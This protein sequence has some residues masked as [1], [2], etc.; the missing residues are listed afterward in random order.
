MLIGVLAG[1][2]PAAA[3]RAAPPFSL[4]ERAVAIAS[5]ALVFVDVGLRGYLRNRVSGQL[6]DE[7]PAVVHRWC[8]GFAVSG[9]G[10]V[11]APT[12]CLLSHPDS[13][14][15]AAAFIV[16]NAMIAGGRLAPAAKN[17][18]IEQV[19]RSAEFTGAEPQSPPA[20]A[21]VTGQ[22]FV[23]TTDTER[24]TAIQGR[25]VDSQPV[26]GGGVTLLKFDT[27]GLPV[28]SL[29][30]TAMSPDLQVVQVSFTTS[31][32]EAQPATYIVRSRTARVTGSHGSSSPQRYRLDGDLGANSD[33][34]MVIDTRGDVIGMITHDQALPGRPNDLL[35][36][37]D[38]ILS[39]LSN[40]GVG[41]ELAPTDEVYRAGLDAY[42]GGYYSDA[43][44]RFESVLAQ[45]PNNLPAQTY[46][47]HATE[48]LAIEG[49]PRSTFPA[50]T[51]IASVATIVVLLGVIAAL[52]LRAW[53]SRAR[54]RA[55]DDLS[56]L[57]E[58]GQYHAV[59][60]RHPPISGAP[61]SG[62]AGA[63][64]SAP[65]DA[66]TAHTVPAGHAAQAVPAVPAWPLAVPGTAP[67]GVPTWAPPG[68]ATSATPGAT[69]ATP[70]WTPPPTQADVAWAPRGP[71]DGTGVAAPG[72]APGQATPPAAAAYPSTTPVAA[73]PAVTF[74]R[75]QSQDGNTVPPPG[76]AP[77]PIDPATGQPK[78]ADDG[79]Q[80][81]S[82]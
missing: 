63:P 20:L 49:D 52:L 23:A 60:V 45:Q 54:D 67:D 57:D 35:I 59:A 12:H 55:Y 68:V 16:A 73:W 10:H 24:A 62:P 46:H 53:R 81:G 27:T 75:D 11:V 43:I 21:S 72:P 80:P 65:P 6:V 71:I 64:T 22:L 26:D 3:A 32:P 61:I 41:N 7:F 36:G 9:D 47:A 48:R 51:I 18:F 29:A 70:A 78:A 82:R 39:L 31:D 15:G 2:Q 44:A 25:V 79:Q 42:F 33:G 40:A 17:A 77:S 66:P 58:M 38:H 34:G 5:P 1:A 74:W 30:P 19:K 56:P 69:P 28:A 50:W 4:E 76:P 37:A 8:S 14:R 13:L